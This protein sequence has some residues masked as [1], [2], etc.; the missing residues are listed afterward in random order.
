MAARE[1]GVSSPQ[2]ADAKAH[3]LPDELIDPVWVVYFDGRP[4]EIN[5][6]GCGYALEEWRRGGKAFFERIFTPES[7]ARMR[8]ATRQVRTS[9]KPLHNVE[10][11]V[12]THGDSA[13]LCHF[14]VNYQPVLGPTGEVIGMRGDARNIT[15]PVRPA[16]GCSP[17][18][19]RRSIA[20]GASRARRPCCATSRS[21]CRHARR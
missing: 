9:C 16:R 13:R 4:L 1:P 19:R 15:D 3:E 10:V 7:L 6:A 5:R 17:P 14:L 21:S 20:R 11:A 18:S 8:A 2:A 12:R